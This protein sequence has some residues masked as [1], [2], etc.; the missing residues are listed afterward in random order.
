MPS[1]TYQSSILPS[2][3]FPPDK[4]FP[5]NSATQPSG[6]AFGAAWRHSCLTAGGSFWPVIGRFAPPSCGFTVGCL[7]QRTRMCQTAGSFCN[8]RFG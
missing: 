8:V 5:L 3:T 6:V 2:T 4:S 7:K 1:F